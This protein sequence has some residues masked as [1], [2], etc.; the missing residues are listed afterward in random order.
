MTIFDLDLL[1][2]IALSLCVGYAMVAAGVDKKLLHVRRRTRC[3]AC[4]RPH[5]GCA[6]RERR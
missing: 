4:G 2:G 1:T 5:D 3:P 6:C